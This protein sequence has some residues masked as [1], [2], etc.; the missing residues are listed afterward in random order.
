MELETLKTILIKENKK[1]EM[2]LSFLRGGRSMSHYVD[3]ANL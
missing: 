1:E 2:S 3:Q